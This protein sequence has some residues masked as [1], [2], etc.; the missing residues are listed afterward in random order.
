MRAIKVESFQKMANFE[1]MLDHLHKSTISSFP[2]IFEE[3][4][5]KTSRARTFV[6]FKG[7]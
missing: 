6:T 2:E 3:I 5:R 1:E 4:R 7:E